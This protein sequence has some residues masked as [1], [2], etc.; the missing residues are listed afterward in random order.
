[1]KPKW[2]R[3]GALVILCAVVLAGCASAAA[4]TDSAAASSSTAPTPA[5]APTAYA[6][7]TDGQTAFLDGYRAYVAHDNLRASDRLTFAAA[8]FPALGDYAL[9]YLALAEHDQGDL[10]ASADTLERLVSLYPDSVLIDPGEMML[11][12][13][14]LKLNRGLEA[15]AV[16]ARL[17]ARC[18]QP[19]I[20]QTARVTEGRALIALGNPKAAYAQLMELRNKYPRS[21]SDA[22]ARV[23]VQSI[24]A[25]NPSVA[26]TNSLTYHHGE[27]EFGS[28]K[29]PATPEALVVHALENLDAKLMIALSS[30]R[31][32]AAAA[33][34]GNWTEYLK[35][36]SGK[37]FRPDVAPADAPPAPAASA[38]S[39]PPVINNPLFESTP[40]VRK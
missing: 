16:A 30:C 13:N 26:D 6:P 11:A 14:L 22:E 1:M 34:E 36:F 35:A 37:M 15:S 21:D 32:E 9:Y 17:I 39:G 4:P 2:W 10:K 29:T 24:L 38:P 25:S 18:P 33:A 12:D 20:E 27:A 19:S 31:G 40:A 28:P 3:G 5:A 23:L 7:P 8:N